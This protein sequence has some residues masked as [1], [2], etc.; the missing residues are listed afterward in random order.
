M[1]SI[2]YDFLADSLFF[3]DSTLETKFRNESTRRI[4]KE[5]ANYRQFC[6]DNYPILI[7]EIKEN[8]SFLNVFSSSTEI[9]L[10][11]LKQTALYI[12]QFIIFDPLFSQTSKETENERV[13]KEFIGLTPTE[14]NKEEVWTSSMFLKSITPM[15]AGDFVKVFPLSYYFESPN[16]IPIYSPE[17]NVK[18]SLPDSVLDYFRNNSKVSNCILK[19]NELFIME[20]NTE[21][22]NAIFIE[23]NGSTGK[24]EYFHYLAD[25]SSDTC[26]TNNNHIII[27]KSSEGQ[28]SQEFYNE[29]V[30]TMISN[31]SSDYYNRVYNEVVIASSLNLNYICDNEFDKDLLNTK[32]NTSSSI[33]E[34]TT[35]EILNIDLPF[36]DNIDIDKLMSVRVNEEQLFTNF[37]MEL[38]RNFREIRSEND[39]KIKKEMI[40]NT[41]HELNDV[42]IPKISQMISHIT[43]STIGGTLVGICGF[44]LNED[45]V[46]NSLFATL[47]AMANGFKD[48]RDYSQNIKSNPSYFL[49]KVKNAN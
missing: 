27:S 17:D 6:I 8:N 49:W 29:W 45:T 38:E 13:I 15:V 1:G 37:R 39:E 46:G 3:N 48:Y 32:V 26:E 24:N 35:N 4:E 33:T 42:Q 18:R 11:L 16:E 43:K 41:F 12:N 31:S 9:Q 22:T 20:E 30:N 5:L 2:V 10:Q 14:I 44:A 36:L 47:L 25:F 28:I 7:K 23:F 34:F 40:E 19:G 21:P